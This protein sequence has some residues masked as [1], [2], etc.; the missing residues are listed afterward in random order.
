[1]IILVKLLVCLILEIFYENFFVKILKY[2]AEASAPYQ[3]I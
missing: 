1:M 3:N 2:I